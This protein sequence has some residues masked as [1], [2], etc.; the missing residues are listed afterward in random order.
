MTLLPP[1]SPFG[2]VL[3]LL[4][5]PSLGR[6]QLQY[7]PSHG[8]LATHCCVANQ[9]AQ[10]LLE[11][12]DG[13]LF[14]VSCYEFQLSRSLRLPYGFQ[15]FPVGIVQGAENSFLPIIPALASGASC[16]PTRMLVRT[17]SP[18]RIHVHKTIR[19]IEMW[20]HSP[21]G[22]PANLCR[23]RCT[24]SRPTYVGS[25]GPL[26]FP[27]RVP[28]GL[29]PAGNAG[30]SD[31]TPRERQSSSATGSTINLCIFCHVFYR[32]SGNWTPFSS[33]GCQ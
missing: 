30:R 33:G 5:F 25:D 9:P 11:G 27:N 8:S 13:R 24:P 1:L 4:L 3:A 12:F 32:K 2:P 26:P 20:F 21:A 19:H 10:D 28:C 16:V 31:T 7:S 17:L 14:V 23:S 29:G 22:P 18:A 6:F 15:C